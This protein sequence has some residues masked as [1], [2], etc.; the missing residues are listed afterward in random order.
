MSVNKK[1]KRKLIYNNQLYYWHVILDEDAYDEYYL[2]IIH[3]DKEFILQYRI[4]QIAD[5]F[6]RPKISILKSNRLKSGLYTF[7]PS[8][9][10][11]IITPKLVVNILNWYE[12]QDETTTPVEYKF[13]K[14]SLSEINYKSGKISFIDDDFENRHED[15]LQV[16][17]PN[18]YSLD[19]GWYGSMSAYIIFVIKDN[20]WETPL[21]KVHTAYYNLKERLYNAVDFLEKISK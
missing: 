13:E 15:M 2:Q 4:N 16:E 10:D 5:E 21:K 6:L 1:G 12:Q 7:F 8:L 3:K 11:K 20:N 9:D 18:G 17:Y 14:I 19:F